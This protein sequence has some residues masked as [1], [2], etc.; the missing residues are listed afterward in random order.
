MTTATETITLEL[1]R[2]SCGECD[3][4]FAVPTTW[5]NRKR[6]D[7][8]DWTCPNGHVRHFIGQSEAEKLR[9]E[10]ARQKHRTEQAEE[11]ARWQRS[12]RTITENRLRAHKGVVTKLKKRVAAGSCPCCHRKFRDLRDHMR[13]EHPDWNPEQGAEAIAAKAK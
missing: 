7:H 2:I 12:Q 1:T 10:L 5:Y 9:D 6:G 11:D 13:A 4:V 3:I 8:T